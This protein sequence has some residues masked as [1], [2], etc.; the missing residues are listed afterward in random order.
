MVELVDSQQQELSVEDIVGIDGM[1]T[2][3]EY[4]P[5]QLSAMLTAELQMP[6]TLFLRQGNTLYIVHKAQPSIGV[7]R[8]INADTQQNLLTNS[9]E[10]IAACYKMGFDTM[11]TRFSNQEYLEIPVFIMEDPPNED[12]GYQLTQLES[13]QYQLVIQCGPVFKGKK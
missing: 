13:G 1:N 4:M 6:N 2:G 8:I 5:A 7:F 11:G 3:Q 9:R 10:F 12:M